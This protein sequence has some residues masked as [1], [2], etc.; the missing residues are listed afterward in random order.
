[1]KTLP[2]RLWFLLF[3]GIG[4]ALLA[5]L[6]LLYGTAPV[7][8]VWV[9][10]VRYMVLGPA[11]AG[12]YLFA[13][14][15]FFADMFTSPESPGY[16]VFLQGRMQTQASLFWAGLKVAWS[17]GLLACADLLWLAIT[18][19]YTAGNE[20]ERLNVFA[21][22]F[23]L[24]LGTVNLLLV[25]KVFIVYA[26]GSSLRR[27]HVAAIEGLASLVMAGLL[28]TIMLTSPFDG[29]LPFV[30]VLLLKVIVGAFFFLQAMDAVGRITRALEWRAVARSKTPIVVP[31]YV[32]Q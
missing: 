9:L 29:V 23:G 27:W 8:K 19:Y 13:A 1:M 17:L 6:L 20:V 30:L 32:R 12:A 14:I 18:V 5:L 31:V 10:P 25:V 4:T 15:I 21:D 22:R 24:L 3:I 26:Y 2:H 16:Q 7:L 28:A 11:I